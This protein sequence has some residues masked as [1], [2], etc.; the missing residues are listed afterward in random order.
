M[1]KVS[2]I[3]LTFM[4]TAC[5]LNAQNCPTLENDID[6]NG[7]DISFAYAS[8][9]NNCCYLCSLNSLCNSFTFVTASQTCW[10]KSTVGQNRLNA[11]G[12]MSLI[13]SAKHRI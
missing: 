12:R 10:L 5:M 3:F 4:A 8:S 2:L 6:Y 7:N 11:V 1:L 13:Y 9:V